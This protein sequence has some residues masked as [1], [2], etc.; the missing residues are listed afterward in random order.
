ME[1]AAP[2]SFDETDTEALLEQRAA[3]PNKRRKGLY[4]V[5]SLLL[6]GVAAMYLFET[7]LTHR[8]DTMVLVSAINLAKVGFG[9]EA[10]KFLSLTVVP[11]MAISF[12]FKREPKEKQIVAMLLRKMGLY[13]LGYGLLLVSMIHDNNAK[14]TM[15]SFCALQFSFF[16][17]DVYAVTSDVTEECGI[18]ETSIY[19]W[20]VINLALG[21]LS[22]LAYKEM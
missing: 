4:V 21:I 1:N 19:P 13:A 7:F 15:A 3:V 16:V 2:I 20:C 12:Y 6:S 22:F 14:G 18:A 5:A 11:N 9:F 10:I 17:Y 8:F